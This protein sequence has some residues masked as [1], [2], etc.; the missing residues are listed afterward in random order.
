MIGE[1]WPQSGLLA[2]YHLA[3]VADASGNGYD[4]SNL[5]TVTFGPG[6]FGNCGLFGAANSSKYLRL[7]S[8]LGIDLSTANITMAAWIYVQTQPDTDEDQDFVM[9]RS[10]TGSG[11][12]AILR[13]EDESGVKYLNYN[14]GNNYA[15]AAVTLDLNRWYFVVGTTSGSTTTLYLD[16]VALATGTRGTTSN[17]YAYVTVGARYTTSAT[18]YFKGNVDEVA[19]FNRAWSAAEVRKWYGWCR[20]MLI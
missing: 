5:G 12:Y 4:L 7:A 8:G 9:W 14:H 19:L 2:L 17:T 16:G 1:L 18:A 13:Y 10:N 11:R 15:R 6:K 20:G 3:D